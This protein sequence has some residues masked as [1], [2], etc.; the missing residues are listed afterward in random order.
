MKFELR[1]A[2]QKEL[3]YDT[4]LPLHTRTDRIANG[5][6]ALGKN[7]DTEVAWEEKKTKK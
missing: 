3:V 4:E 7:G 1:T 5:I 6:L 2:G